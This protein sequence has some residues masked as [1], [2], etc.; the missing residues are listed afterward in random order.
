MKFTKQLQMRLK[1]LFK[2][3][4]KICCNIAHQKPRDPQGSLDGESTL[5]WKV[6]KVLQPPPL[7]PIYTIYWH[8]F[9]YETTNAFSDNN[10]RL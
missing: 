2:V 7:L 3:D 6:T 8:N 10:P 5:V 1:L 4:Y 9:G